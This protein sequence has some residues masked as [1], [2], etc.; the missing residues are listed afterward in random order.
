MDISPVLISIQTAAVS[1]L[2]TF[3]LGTAAAGAVLFCRRG[4]LRETL[5]VLF[6]LPLVLPPTVAGFFL[7]ELFGARGPLGRFFLEFFGVR[8]VFTRSAAVL[9]AAVMSFPLMYRSARG[10]L[11][12]VDRRLLP[13][14]KTLGM[15]GGQAFFRVLL[16]NAGA[17]LLSGAILSFC[18]G[19]GEFGATAM[20]AGNI[21]QKTRTLPLAVYAAVA[22]G[23]M[24]TAYRY[25]GILVLICF[26]AVF[27]MNFLTRRSAA[28]K[29]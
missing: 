13:A 20:I 25:V 10:A 11:E 21:A 26:A 1:I 4:W 16:P 15:S 3:F 12:Q 18:R 14:A 5:D 23:D 24:E 6:T 19:L 17:G 22:A 8:V 29:R 2:I 9:A 28:G 27:V 7:L